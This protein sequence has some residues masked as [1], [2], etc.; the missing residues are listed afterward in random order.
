MESLSQAIIA[1]RGLSL[2]DSGNC[3]RHIALL[4]LLRPLVCR[5]WNIL[6]YASLSDNDAYVY[7]IVRQLLIPV[8]ITQ[9]EHGSL[10]TRDIAVHTETFF[11]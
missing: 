10:Y 3:L 5:V 2:C 1:T 7:I 4:Q 9:S 6:G 8:V 11:P